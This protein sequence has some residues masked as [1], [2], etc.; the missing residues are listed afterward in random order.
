ML[1]LSRNCDTAI[2]I[3]GEVKVKVLSIRR[4]QVKLGIDAPKSVAVWRE[5]LFS[6]QGQRGL[7]PEEVATA[8]N[9][10]DQF[11]TLLVEDDP[12]HACLISEALLECCFSQPTVAP[13][14]RAAMEVLG[15]DGHTGEN[16]LR[17]R[18]VLLDLR[19]PDMPGLEV[20]RYIRCTARLRT[21]PVVILSVEDRDSV[22]ASCLELGANAFVT[23]SARYQEFRQSVS[24]IAAFWSTDCRV[25]E[26][27]VLSGA[28]DPRLPAR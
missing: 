26:P 23:K 12:A 5:E 15:G 20:L 6:E 17:P 4:R 1:V 14:G 25:P 10:G 3:G 13:T 21:T 24:R 27:A 22:V 7:S 8:P 2:R 18:L 11:F 16:V 28:D 9:G 19:L